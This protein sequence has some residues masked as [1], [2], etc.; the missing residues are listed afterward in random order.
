MLFMAVRLA[1]ELTARTDVARF[2]AGEMTA[3]IA[4]V[5]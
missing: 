2:A 4:L 5:D 3:M 1:V